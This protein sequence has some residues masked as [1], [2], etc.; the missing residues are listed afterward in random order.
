MQPQDYTMSAVAVDMSLFRP[1]DRVELLNET[2]SAIAIDY[3]KLSRKLQKVEADLAQEKAHSGT[4]TVEL[5]LKN[6]EIE[7]LNKQL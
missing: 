4:L 2:T 1:Q 7:S 3:L 6:D 5:K